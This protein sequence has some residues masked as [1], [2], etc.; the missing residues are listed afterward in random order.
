MAARTL[1]FEAPDGETTL[2]ATCYDQDTNTLAT[3]GTSS[4]ATELAANKGKY[5]CVF[6]DLATGTYDLR[7]ADSGNNTIARG[8]LQHTNSTGTERPASI[9]WASIASPDATVSLSNTTIAT[10]TNLA[11]AALAAIWSYATRTLTGASQSVGNSLSAGATVTAYRA[12]TWD[13][14]LTGLGVLTGWTKLV[15]TLRSDLDAD[16]DDSLV[17]IQLSSPSAASDGLLY[18]NGAA[19]TTKAN[20]SIV[21]NDAVTGSITISLAAVESAKLSHQRTKYDVKKFV[22]STATFMSTE[23]IWQIKASPTRASS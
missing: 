1:A 22:G 12:S 8:I 19:A 11:T 3:N 17:Q 21:V 18:I 4:T 2:V 7:I 16:D 5:T 9:D 13:V 14:T 10:V 23:G 20:G 15:V 6:T